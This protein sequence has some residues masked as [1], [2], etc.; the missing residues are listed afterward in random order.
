MANKKPIVIGADGLEQLQSGDSLL[1]DQPLVHTGS[2]LGFF[3]ATPISQPSASAG[4]ATGLNGLGTALNNLGLVSVGATLVSSTAHV[5]AFGNFSPVADELVYWDGAAYQSVTAPTPS[6]DS[7]FALRD[8]AGVPAWGEIFKVGGSQQSS[9]GAGWFHWNTSTEALTFYDTDASAWQSV[10]TDLGPAQGI[11]DISLL[12]RGDVIVA[13]ATPALTN[14]AIGAAGTVFRSD[15]TDPSWTTISYV[16]TGTPSSPVDGAFWLDNTPGTAQIG[17]YDAGTATWF[18]TY[19]NNSNLNTLAQETVTL[20]DLRVGGGSGDYIQ[21]ALGTTGQTLK[22]GTSTVEW[23]DETVLNPAAPGSPVLAD[24]WVETSEQKLSIY[25]GSDWVQIETSIISIQNNELTDLAPGTAVYIQSAGVKRAIA[26]DDL[27]G[28]FVGLVDNDSNVASTA[29]AKVKVSDVVTKTTAQ[30]NAV[31]RESSP[32]GLAAGSYYYLTNDTA[33][34]ITT[35]PDMPPSSTT[36][37]LPVKIGIAL[38]STKMLIIPFSGGVNVDQEALPWVAKGDLMSYTGSQVQRVVVGADGEIPI[39]DS[40]ETVGIRWGSV[41]DAVG[42]NYVTDASAAYTLLSTDRGK[43]VNLTNA[44]TVALSCPAGFPAGYFCYAQKTGNATGFDIA[45]SGG[46]TVTGDT[47]VRGENSA[48]LIVNIG[49][50]AYHVIQLEQHIQAKGGIRTSNGTED[51]EVAVGT[52]GQVLVANSAIAAGVEW[53]D[54]QTTTTKGDL[55]THDGTGQALLAVGGNQ[56][57]LV[58]DSSTTEGIK[59]E[60]PDQFGLFA[61]RRI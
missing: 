51:V 22:V 36:L 4:L 55:V 2:T 29:Q 20:G 26:D 56:E 1:L 39:A 7:T 12:V 15:G 25:D 23:R 59:W 18:R 52:N 11:A 42:I 43:L 31:I 10:V 14:L 53:Q 24:K 49:S 34:F 46:A 41:S 35:N 9:P 47:S 32:G 37:Y 16:Q 40:L 45:G 21:L 44:A 33:G 28:R 30:W 5:D 50:N 38:S 57:V 13:N 8:V 6:S 3:G 19:A 27:R 61:H 58:A 17:I 54:L 60:L 48:A